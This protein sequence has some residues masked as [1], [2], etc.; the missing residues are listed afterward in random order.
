MHLTLNIKPG[1]LCLICLPIEVYYNISINKKSIA[2]S[3]EA[4]LL[5][6]EQ[7]C[8]RYLPLIGAR[9]KGFQIV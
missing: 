3:N 7:R 9:G 4:P 1:M 8:Y 6:G 2:H 5:S